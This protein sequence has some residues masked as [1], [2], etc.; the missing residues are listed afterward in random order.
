M[1]GVTLQGATDQDQVVVRYPISEHVLIV[2]MND[3][4]DGLVLII[5]LLQVGNESIVGVHACRLAL[6]LV[7]VDD[8]GLDQ[9]VKAFIL[10]AIHVLLAWLLLL[11]HAHLILLLHGVFHHLL[12]RWLLLNF[13][14][15]LSAK[16]VLTIFITAL[17]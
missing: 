5:G 9:L 12:L 13:Y 7:K 15:L 8:V 17:N 11:V 2:S 3:D 1:N 14:H 10:L 4:V 16:F 6:L